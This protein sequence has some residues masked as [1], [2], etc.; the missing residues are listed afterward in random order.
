MIIGLLYGLKTI[1]NIRIY[2]GLIPCEYDQKRKH[3]REQFGCGQHLR[4]E[5]WIQQTDAQTAWCT[6]KWSKCKSLESAPNP[7]KNLSNACALDEPKKTLSVY[8]FNL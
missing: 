1:N 4:R 3:N 7:D 2:N 5:I 6:T 8:S